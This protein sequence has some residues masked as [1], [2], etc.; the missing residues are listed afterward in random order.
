ME[1]RDNISV[2]DKLPDTK[3]TNVKRIK[4]NREFKNCIRLSG[5][6]EVIGFLLTIGPH[7]GM[8]EIIDGLES[9]NENTWDRWCHFERKHFNL[10]MTV[11]GNVQI[12]ILQTRFDTTSC[13]S[14]MDFT[15]KQKKLI[16]HDIYYVG[17][18]L[19]VDNIYDGYKIKRISPIMIN[20]FG[21]LNQYKK[22]LFKK[23]A[24]RIFRTL[25]REG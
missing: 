7:S 3:Y 1:N 25:Y 16:V 23:H 12:N 10:S 13:K 17:N 22:K 6:C 5:N 20:A 4:V 9:Y 18:D 2:P 15:K 19:V 21:R 8:V 11:S 24:S 14:Q